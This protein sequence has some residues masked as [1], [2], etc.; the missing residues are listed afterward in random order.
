MKKVLFPSLIVAMA[1]AM[2]SFKPMAKSTGA[3]DTAS[4]KTNVSAAVAKSFVR[5]YTKGTKWSVWKEVWTLTSQAS[6]VQIGMINQ[7]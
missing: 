7:Y 3:Y 2:F 5:Y 4:A 1:L 6:N